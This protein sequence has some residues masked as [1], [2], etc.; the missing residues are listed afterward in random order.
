[1]SVRPQRDAQMVPV[2]EL[3]QQVSPV[4]GSKCPLH[5]SPGFA[6]TTREGRSLALRVYGHFEAAAWCHNKQIKITSTFLHIA[7]GG[8]LEAI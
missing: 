7:H 2:V 5:S 3:F 4:H 8:R 1:M 6:E